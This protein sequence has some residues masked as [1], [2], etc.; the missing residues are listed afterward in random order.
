MN[1]FPFLAKL[2]FDCHPFTK[3]EKLTHQREEKVYRVCTTTGTFSYPI[4]SKL[5]LNPSINNEYVYVTINLI[6]QIV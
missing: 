4:T 2:Y 3:S 6:I 1:E 5:L